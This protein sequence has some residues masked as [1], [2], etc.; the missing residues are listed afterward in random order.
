ME[1]RYQTVLKNRNYS[2]LLAANLV[3]RFGDSIDTIAFS[4]LVYSFTGEGMWAAIAF[5][6]NKIPSVVMLPLLGAYVEKHKKKQ[7]MI[8]CDLV[9]SVLVA[10]LIICLCTNTITLALLLSLSFGISVAE[11][12]RIPAGVSFITLLL[13]KEELSYG[14]S[15]NILVSML[16]EM[17]GTGAGGVIV[18]YMGVKSAFVID[19]VT[20]LISIG[21][22]CGIQIDEYIDKK[23]E[24]KSSFVIFKEGLQYVNSRKKLIHIIFFAMFV[25]AAMAPLDSLQTPIVVEV[26][27]QNATY[28]SIVNICVTAGMVLGGI[29]YPVLQKKIR[30]GILLEMGQ[31]WIVL[32]YLMVVVLHKENISATGTWYYIVAFFY[33]LYGLSAG[34]MTAALGVLLMKYTEQNYMARVNTIYTALGEAIVPVVSA[35]SGVFLTICGMDI[36]FLIIAICNSVVLVKEGRQCYNKA[37]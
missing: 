24:Q 29:V 7:I 19:I 18:G 26:L 5:A 25:N 16:A 14:V 22:I 20:F 4:W 28:L 13:G 35:A 11:A 23:M 27:R 31:I 15:L 37:N 12:F 32:M 33:F 1:V 36:M 10:I 9:R 21:M 2:C 30:N 3:N 17:I 8:I 34:I 6:I